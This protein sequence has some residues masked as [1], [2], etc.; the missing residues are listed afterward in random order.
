MFISVY[1][2]NKQ[3]LVGRQVHQSP[4]LLSLLSVYEGNLFRACI[5]HYSMELVGQVS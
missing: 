1:I 3:Y 5:F 4:I 2:V